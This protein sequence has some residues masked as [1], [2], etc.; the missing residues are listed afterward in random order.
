MKESKL[1]SS[2]LPSN[3][4]LLPIIQAVR[5]K[6]N[7][8]EIS[9]DDDPITEIYMGDQIIPLE[10]LRMDI[11]SRVRDNL[12][13]LPPDISKLYI[14]SKGIRDFQA[15]S[16]LELLPDDSK[17]G[18]EEAVKFIQNLMIPII[19]LIDGMIDSIVKIVYIYILTGETEEAQVDWFSTVITANY[20]GEPVVIAMASKMADPK[21]ISQQF[22]EEYK[23]TFG[24]YYPN[25]T[26]TAVSTAYYV[27]LK[28]SHKPWKYIVETYIRLNNIN[29]PKYHN[30][31]RYLDVHGKIEQNLKKRIQ[32][33]EIILQGLIRDRKY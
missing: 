11:E 21:I 19:Q 18:M 10:E 14:A 33:T 9:P 27:Q 16:E 26:Q 31:K 25:I 17:K 12:T 6:Y 29:L 20:L 3:P 32:R 1:F 2:L 5:E 7:L 4:D 8:A 23:R 28:R 24:L 22:R 30:S 13:I 15:T